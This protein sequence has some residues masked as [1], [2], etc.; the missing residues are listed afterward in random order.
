M[1]T[2]P[3]AP[4][5]PSPANVRIGS[6]RL[7]SR[8]FWSLVVAVVLVYGSMGMWFVVNETRMVYHPSRLVPPPESFSGFHHERVELQT[9]D[10]LRLVGWEMRTPAGDSSGA[11]LL[12]LHGNAGN[13]S[14]WV[15]R[16]A[17]L[18]K[19]GVNVFTADYRGYG[20]SEGRPEEQGLYLDAETM[21]DHLIEVLRVPPQR[22][23][24]Y[25]HSLG[26]GVAVELAVRRKAACLIVEG[27]FTSV[28]D[29]GQELYPYLPIRLFA[30]NHF[31]SIHK[32]GSLTIPKLFIH[33][34]EDNVVP[35]SHG[36]KLY[37]AAAPP[38]TFL[39]LHGGHSSAIFHDEETFLNG[40]Q[41]FLINLHVVSSARRPILEPVSR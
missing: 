18:Q 7:L 1:Q 4:P 32:V 11:W 5:A 35:F 17:Q 6:R 25:G 26:S 27:A 39:E 41:A 23:I 12:Y 37:E 33:A 34:V 8:F 28:T 24:I 13:I 2:P 22:V 14:E 15:D 3:P 38:K 40:V 10:H 30:Q 20:E 31:D 21:Y 9:K 29:R 36:Q 19:L 16:Y